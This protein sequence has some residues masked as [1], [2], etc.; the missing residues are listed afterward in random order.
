MIRGNACGKGLNIKGK[1]A[2]RSVVSGLVPFLQISVD[3]DK[4][5]VEESPKDARIRVYFAAENLRDNAKK[6]AEDVRNDMEEG[7]KVAQKLQLE[8]EKGLVFHKMSP[9]EEK[10]HERK[11]K[12]EMEDPQIIDVEYNGGAFGLD[13]PE[14]LFMETWVMRQNISPAYEWETGRASEP[15]SQNMN[16][17][18][19]RDGAAHKVRTPDDQKKTT[20]TPVVWQFDDRWE[21]NPRGLVLAYEETYVLPVASD[22]DG[23]CFGSKGMKIESVPSEQVELL[24]WTL[25]VIDELLSGHHKSWMGAWIQVLQREAEKGFHPHIPKWGFG[26]PKTSEV[27]VALAGALSVS[28]AVRHGA[29]CFNF[30]FPQDLDDEYLIIWDGFTHLN[31]KNVGPG[32]LRK[33]LVE[34]AN[35]GYVFPINPKWV[36]ADGWH[37]VWAA[38]MNHKEGAEAMKKWYPPETCNILERIEGLKKKYPEGFKPV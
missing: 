24:G 4:Y 3:E 13:M 38:M 23:F 10:E 17:H 12:W 20:P 8:L 19:T 18:A 35:E 34:R 5:R 22:M 37:E 2:K 28:G 30:F 11:L 36:I 21:M 26:D 14:R 15:F 33:F 32:A 9:E 31:W 7:F 16:L 25:D 1:S 6:H 27:T 29:E